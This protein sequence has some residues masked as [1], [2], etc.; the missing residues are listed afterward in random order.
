[1]AKDLPRRMLYKDKS[2]S[3][4]AEQVLKTDRRQNPK[5]G[6]FSEIRSREKKKSDHAKHSLQCQIKPTRSRFHPKLLLPPEVKVVDDLKVYL[7][8]QREFGREGV[9]G[10]GKGGTDDV[11]E[12]EFVKRGSATQIMKMK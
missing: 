9:G 3:F 4:L 10:R 2:R 8:R 12:A 6:S 7:Q 5:H 1:M 11:Q